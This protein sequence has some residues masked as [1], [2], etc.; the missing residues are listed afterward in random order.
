ME[1]A[2]SRKGTPNSVGPGLPESQAPM[3]SLASEHYP[4]QDPL[5]DDVVSFAYGSAVDIV[6]LDG[7]YSRKYFRKQ[8]VSAVLGRSPREG[9]EGGLSKWVI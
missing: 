1:H 4:L 8:P 9:S 2:S 5:L 3:G 7:R 6:C